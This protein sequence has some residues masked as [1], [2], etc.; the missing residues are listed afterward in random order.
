M[1]MRRFVRIAVAFVLLLYAFVQPANG[2][3]VTKV[4]GVVTDSETGG[5]VPFAVVYF[6]GTTVGVTTD[7]D[8]LYYIETRQSVSDTIVVELM[9][10][11]GE[12]TRR[13]SATIRPIWRVSI[14]RPTTRW[15]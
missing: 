14:V 1:R 8:G 13:K 6:K 5:P 4:K 3:Q 10:Y 15:S 2:Q 7:M 9:G 11:E 12:Y